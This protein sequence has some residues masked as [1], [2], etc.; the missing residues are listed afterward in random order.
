MIELLS[1]PLP[2][3]VAGPLIGLVVPMLLLAGG[4]MFGISSNFRTMCA[5]ALP[6]R[7]E[8]F[9]FDWR[10]RGGWNLLFVLGLVMGGILAGV[11]FA[12]PEPIA[13]S[14]ATIRDLENLGLTDFSG[15]VPAELFRWEMLATLPGI[16][17]L[18]VGG[19]LV[20]F[21]ASYAGGCT[22]GHSIM[23]IAD[24]QL[25]SLVATAAFFAG[26]LIATWLL[27]PLIL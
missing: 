13:L 15:L 16:S 25:P 21:G 4:R 6:G 10:A 5:A 7:V 11:V 26:G 19:F 8:F 3:Y 1:R 20:G 18:V 14:A 23:G 24:L 2:W 27:L 9:R 17:M 22:S 12:N